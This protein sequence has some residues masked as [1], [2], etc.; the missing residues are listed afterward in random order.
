MKKKKEKK[1][2][3]LKGNN[4][5]FPSPEIKTKTHDE[6]LI[7]R[8]TGSVWERERLSLTERSS[9][10]RWGRYCEFIRL[11]DRS[12]VKLTVH[13]PQAKVL[14]V[15]LTAALVIKALKESKCDWKKIKNIK[16]NGNISLDDV[17]E[18]AK[19]T[20][21]RSMAKHLSGTVKEIISMCIS[22]DCTVDRKDPKD[23]Q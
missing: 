7:L 1:K 13:N 21:P 3:T 23:L 17:V 4:T 2:K 11:K 22:M 14:V 10:R 20:C 12:A 8:K 6:F 9:H 16:H 18:T 5:S 19:V 15:P